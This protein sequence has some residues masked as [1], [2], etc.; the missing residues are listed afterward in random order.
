VGLSFRDL[1]ELFWGDRRLEPAK[2]PGSQP[3]DPKRSAFL[4]GR[5][6]PSQFRVGLP[7]IKTIFAMRELTELV[8]P[9]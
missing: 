8:P 1:T 5:H 6:Q 3:F 7:A 9:Y 2:T 4:A